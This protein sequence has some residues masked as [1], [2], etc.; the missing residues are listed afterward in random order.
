MVRKRSHDV[1]DATSDG[2]WAGNVHSFVET[3]IKA[4]WRENVGGR[5]TWNAAVFEKGR[6]ERGKWEWEWEWE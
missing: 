2:S 5:V 1:P 4:G 6:D 3:Y